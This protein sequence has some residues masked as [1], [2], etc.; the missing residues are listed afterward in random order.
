[1]G[2]EII[3]KAGFLK[4]DILGVK[5][6]DKVAAIAKLVKEN[7]N[8][9]ITFEDIELDDPSVFELF[10][11]GL[12]EDTFQFGTAGLK[13]FCREMKPD[14]INDLIAAVALYRPGTMENGLHKKYVN[15][16]NGKEKPEYDEGTYE[17]TKET[18]GIAVYQEQVMQITVDVAGFDL[19]QADDV[20]KAM[21]K[22]D[23]K[24]LDEQ[25]MKFIQ[26]GRS[27]GYKEDY[28]SYLWS[29]LETFAGY[30]FNKSHAAAY[31]ITGYYT[32]WL[33]VHYPLEFW[34]VSLHYAKEEEIIDR[35]SEINKVSKIQVAS[36]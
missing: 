1:M 33:K 24:L 28:L 35:I 31:A 22:K 21:G 2:R 9:T 13:A 27:K 20:R 3:D 7:H 36:V 34:T 18:F 30:G 26:G 25:K 12:N 19:V 29:K 11:E 32:Q 10:K 16:K 5:Q 8:E 17:A 15:I 14:N 23:R 4:C 6:L